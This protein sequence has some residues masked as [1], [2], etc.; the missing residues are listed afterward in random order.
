MEEKAL[1]KLLKAKKD[2]VP[3]EDAFDAATTQV[4]ESSTG[5]TNAEMLQL[6]GLFKQSTDGD[7][8]VARPEG[9]TIG[10][11][12]WYVRMPPRLGI[13]CQ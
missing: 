1:K 3:P 5:L 13:F 2:V 7:V 8:N 11:A 12:K 9:D 4:L 6:F 10:A